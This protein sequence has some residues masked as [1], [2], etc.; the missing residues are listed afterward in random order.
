MTAA[1]EHTYLG[2]H[3]YLGVVVLKNKIC[4]L[5]IPNSLQTWMYIATLKEERSYNYNDFWTEEQLRHPDITNLSDITIKHV[6]AMCHLFFFFLHPFSWVIVTLPK[7]KKKRKKKEFYSTIHIQKLM[8]LVFASTALLIWI[9]PD[10]T[11]YYWPSKFIGNVTL[12][13]CQKWHIV[14][15]M[16]TCTKFESSEVFQ[17]MLNK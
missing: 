17:H 8:H 7:K 11:G 13:I 4:A 6:S 3:A 15:T 12:G 16:L 2:E 9:L 10:Y 14:H 1:S 5:Y